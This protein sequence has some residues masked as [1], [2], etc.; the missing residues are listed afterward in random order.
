MGFRA[1]GDQASAQQQLSDP[2]ARA[3]QIPAQV[4]PGTN[5]I[6]Q[7]LKLQHGTRTGRSCPAANS[8]ASFNASRVSV[9]V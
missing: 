9:L 5:E 8:R 1:R 6:A 7:R 4:L 2:M 3:H